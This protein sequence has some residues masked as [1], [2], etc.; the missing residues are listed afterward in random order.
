M[1]IEASKLVSTQWLEDHLVSTKV[2]VLDASWY[3]PGEKRDPKKEFLQSHIPGAEYF[4]IDNFSDRTN[5]LPHMVP[6]SEKF[7][8]ELKKIGVSDHHHII[9]YDGAG[10]FSASRAWWLFKLFDVGAVSILDGGFPKWVLEKRPVSSKISKL[11]GPSVNSKLKKHYV[12]NWKDVKKMALS[13]PSQIVDARSEDR[14]FGN[15]PEPR[16]GLRSGHIPKSTNICY[17]EL[18]ND[19]NTFKDFES[20]RNVF[21]SK[22]VDIKRPIIASCGSGV[23][24]AIIF[25]ALDLLGAKSVALYDGSW[26]EWGSRPDL[27]VDRK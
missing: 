8:D 18:L 23:T 5:H 15:A 22:G 6:T 9:V 11:A 13:D 17:K 20:L 16:A 1:K 12:C 2:K 4:D 27:P 24:A 7:D 3:L 25:F 19:D 26:C 14:F 21:T 10:Q